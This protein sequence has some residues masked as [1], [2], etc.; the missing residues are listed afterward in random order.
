MVDAG[1][2]SPQ[3][4]ADVFEA[5]LP[6]KYKDGVCAAAAWAKGLQ[7]LV[8]T[9]LFIMLLHRIWPDARSFLVCLLSAF[10]ARLQRGPMPLLETKPICE[11]QVGRRTKQSASLLSACSTCCDRGQVGPDEILCY[12]EVTS[13]NT[14]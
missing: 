11:Q 13:V 9:V 12:V 10:L 6:R 3:K 2:C 5:S 4:Y 14:A 8:S 7:P 1:Q